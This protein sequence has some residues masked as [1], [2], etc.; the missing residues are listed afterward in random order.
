VF[1]FLADPP[2]FP[3]LVADVWVY[4]NPPEV[5]ANGFAFPR[6]KVVGGDRDQQREAAG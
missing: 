2:P 5:R 3:A 1:V 6:F 4:G